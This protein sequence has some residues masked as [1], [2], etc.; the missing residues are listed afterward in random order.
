VNVSLAAAE[1]LA[2]QGIDISIADMRFVKPLDEALVSE[3]AQS[4]DQLICI[5][6]NATIGGAGSAVLEYLAK[7][8]LQIP[9][10]LVGIPDRYIEH[11]SPAEQYTD[12]GI[13]CDSLVGLI[14]SLS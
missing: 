5:E 14:S 9:C 11:A 8:R 2:Q 4:H 7:Q 12:V 13:D 1:R 3:L 10:Q 6:E